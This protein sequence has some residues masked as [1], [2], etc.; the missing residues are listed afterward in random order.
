MSNHQRFFSLTQK[1]VYIVNSLLEEIN[2]LD[3]NSLEF[4]EKAREL[5]NQIL[6]IMVLDE[7][8]Q[9]IPRNRSLYFNHLCSLEQARDRWGDEGFLDLF[10][11]KY[12][13]ASVLSLL[14]FIQPVKIGH[15]AECPAVVLFLLM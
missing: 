12:S 8:H 14:C 10:G 7:K 4:N 2:F 5:M 3:E 15:N 9:L 11:M 1:E 13:E 6:E